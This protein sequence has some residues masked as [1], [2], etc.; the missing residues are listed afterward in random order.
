MFVGTAITYLDGVLCSA[1]LAPVIITNIKLACKGV[2]GTNTVSFSSS[3]SDVEKSFVTLTP[4]VKVII[5]TCFI[6]DATYK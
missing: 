5:N 2:P 4:S 6:T 1:M 3:I